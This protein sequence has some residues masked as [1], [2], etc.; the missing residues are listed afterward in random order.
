MQNET[1]KTLNTMTLDEVHAE[2][3]R[4]ID[5]YKELGKKRLAAIEKQRERFQAGLP[6]DFSEIENLHGH[7]SGHSL[8]P[9]A[10]YFGD[11][12]ANPS[13]EGD[14]DVASDIEDELYRRGWAGPILVVRRLPPGI[15]IAPPVSAPGAPSGPGPY[16]QNQE[17]CGYCGKVK[18]RHEWCWNV[19]CKSNQKRNGGQRGEKL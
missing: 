7:P 18:Q 1:P 16:G 12:P 10:P 3:D 11:R 15:G 6:V 14:G 17:T 9:I 8:E 19:R 13:P 2:A 5:S 4:I